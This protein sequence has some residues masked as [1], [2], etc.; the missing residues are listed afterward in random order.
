MS[1]DTQAASTLATRIDT[2]LG[3]MTLAEK[4]T[5]LQAESPAIARLGIPEY[6]WWNEALHGVARNGKATVFPQCIGMGATFD[7]ALIKRVYRTIAHEARAKYAASALAGMRG[8]YRGLTFWTPNI[9]I[10]RDPRWGRG[11]ETFG[12]DPTLTTRMGLSAVEGLQGEQPETEL[13]TAACAKHFAVHSG[14][15]ALRH[16]FDAQVSLQDLHET[17]LPAFKALVEGGVE[18]VMGAYNR[19]LGEPCCGSQLLLVDLLRNT[20]GFEGHVVS[21]C[22]AVRDFHEAHGT[23]RTPAESAALALNHGCDLNCGCMYDKL[24]LA[25]EQGLITEAQIDISLRR[26]LRTR[27]R[28]GMFDETEADLREMAASCDVAGEAHRA[29]SHEV[30]TKSIVMVRNE[31]HIL[32]LPTEAIN[33]YLCGPY[34][35]SIDALTGNYSGMSGRM[36]SML[37]GLADRSGASANITYSAAF[38]PDMPNR[39]PAG[40]TG[41]IRECRAADVAVAVVGYDP[42]IEG[43]EGDAI[44]SATGGDRDTTGLPQSQYDALMTLT[45]TDTPIVLVV[46]G[47]SAISLGKLAERCAA[48]LYCWYPGEAG[49]EA[50]ADIIFGNCSPAGRL[51]I[52][53]PTD[54]TQLPPFEDYSMS[55]RTYRFMTATPLYPFGYGLSFSTFAYEAV[56]PATTLLEPWE[57]VDVI[58]QVRNTGPREADEVVQLYLQDNDASVRVPQVKLVDFARV[59]ILPGEVMDVP[60]HVP[61]EAFALI[62][63]DGAPEVEV[64]T[65]TLIA[66][67][68]APIPRALELGAPTPA[69]ITLT[70]G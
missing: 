29:L 33:I 30:A 11:Q 15:E 38:L 7:D 5:Q 24:P 55:G 27:F 57:P 16:E 26:L 60:L 47:G 9:N 21:D 52:T 51:P 22:W 37:E 39:N 70:V 67:G 40:L 35:T 64:G 44:G 63:E 31:A 42:S 49:G 28:L 17:Y 43:E 61:A 8:Q 25:Y 48:I 12:E 14:P 32:P 69:T 68:A 10:F 50:V 62:R 20:W 65:F 53:V 4:M 58:V 18:T 23:T 13:L 54:T 19:T 2:L 3:Q 46:C 36:T 45:E 6:N 59:S 1:N 41:V 34:A 56:L 66:A